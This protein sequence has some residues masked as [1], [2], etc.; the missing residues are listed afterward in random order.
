LIKGVKIMVYSF[1]VLAAVIC[2]SMIVL[3]FLSSKPGQT[4]MTDGRLRPCPD[5]PNCVCSEYPDSPGYIQAIS[6]TG[7]PTSALKKVRTIID[8]MN[9]KIAAEQEGYLHAV[10][11]TPLFRF[12]D[13]LEIRMDVD[14]RLLHIR[15]ASRVGHS[16]LGANRKR[17]KRFWDHFKSN[18]DA[19]K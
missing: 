10:F 4:G 14:L 5:T 17:V 7:D 9:G 18:M 15:S 3:S 19:V 8:Q 2:G 16:D 6:F 13:D 1:P 11:S 12:K